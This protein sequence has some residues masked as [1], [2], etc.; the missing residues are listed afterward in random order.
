VWHIDLRVLQC[1]PR[2]N[3]MTAK[4]PGHTDNALPDAHKELQQFPYWRR[5]LQALPF[6]S[7]LTSMGF[8]L[9]FPFL[10]LMLYSLG[11]EK[12]LETWIGNMMLVFYVISFLCGPIWGGIADHY[13][14][15]IMVLRAMLGMGF[16]MS[17]IPFAPTPLWFACLFSLVG[18]FNGSSMSA[19]A[20]I[21]A[22]TPPT[23]ISSALSRLQTAMLIGQTAGPALATTMVAVVDKPH[24]LFWMSGG[25]LLT[26]GMMVIAFVRETKQLAS[27]PWRPQWIGS[28]RTLIAVPRIGLLFFL[29]FV[30]AMLSFGNITVLSVYTLQLLETQ[31]AGSGSSAFWIGA[32]AVGLG[33][34][35]VLS[36]SLFGRMLDRVDPVRMLVFATAAA[37]ITQ[38]P[39]M[40]LQTPLQLVIARIAFGL[41]APLMLPSIIRLLRIYSPQ[42]MDARA[43]SYS[44]SFQFIA[45]GLAPFCAGVIG[46]I[47]GLRAYFALTVAITFVAFALWL[48]SYKRS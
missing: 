6:A 40:V 5:N 42:G 13:G 2:K 18:F 15:K 43:I 26:A 19:Q 16:F 11:V 4:P 47:F 3:F 25:M 36:L 34:S 31:P 21:V 45:M 29:G 32:V 12:N 35:S 20:L 33:V 37:G 1:G 30:F 24:W 48:R 9:C 7:L 46:P 41:T 22:T 10:P 8:S 44:S 14:R 39:L 23:R 38:L 17:L 27:G 28:L